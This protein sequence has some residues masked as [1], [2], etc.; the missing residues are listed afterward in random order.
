M[1]RNGADGRVKRWRELLAG[2][3]DAAALY[4][5]IAEAETGERRNIFEEL[6]AVERRH[7]AHWEEKIRG[8]GE[9]VPPAGRPSMRTRLLATAASRLSPG[10]VLPMIERAERAD[11]GMY[12]ADPD[13]APG[14][15]SDER[16]HARALS[17]LIEGGKPDP[18]RQIAKREAWH[19][20]DRSGAMRAAVFGVSDGLVSNTS[21]VMGF[22]GSGSSRSA[23]VLAG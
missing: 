2:E 4:T 11:A 8:A 12:D 19:R 21:L 17:K 10:A 6:A 1:S 20:G 23:I 18:R 14:M 5:R 16:G 13:A 7:A 3:R 9:T 15:A 22:A